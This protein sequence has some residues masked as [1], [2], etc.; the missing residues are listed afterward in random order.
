MQ[1]KRRRRLP[2]A[3]YLI[4]ERVLRRDII[5]WLEDLI[6][7]YILKIYWCYQIRLSTSNASHLSIQGEGRGEM[8][9][10]GIDDEK[11]RDFM[12]LQANSRKIPLYTS[13]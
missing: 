4:Y 6:F 5:L 12:W 1:F 8:D 2:E 11:F 10:R 7:N 13:Q 3:V 9:G